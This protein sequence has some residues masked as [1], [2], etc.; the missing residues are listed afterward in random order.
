MPA[1][2]QALAE[3]VLQLDAA[4]AAADPAVP[5]DR[6]LAWCGDPPGVGPVP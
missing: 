5:R 1:G 3:A 4:A 2:R 6:F